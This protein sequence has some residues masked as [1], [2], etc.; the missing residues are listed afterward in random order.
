MT[1]DQLEKERIK[2]EIVHCLKG[3]SEIMKII[4][5]ISSYPSMKFEYEESGNGCPV[6]LD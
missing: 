4:I 2:N 3:E 6:S 1:M 5:F